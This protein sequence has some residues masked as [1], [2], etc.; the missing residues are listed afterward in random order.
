M[1]CSY[2]VDPSFFS[3]FS[4]R[5]EAET[6]ALAI[7]VL[8]SRESPY[9]RLVVFSTAY[10]DPAPSVAQR[11]ILIDGFLGAAGKPYHIL[12]NIVGQ[13]IP[14]G[15]QDM[16]EVTSGKL[17]ILCLNS[18]HDHSGEWHSTNAY[19]NER[20]TEDKYS[21]DYE[22]SPWSSDDCSKRA[23]IRFSATGTFRLP[24][25]RGAA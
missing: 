13:P 2:I 23:D 18:F 25:S 24:P 3:A 16:V 12:K 1:S 5:G 14:N 19:R 17:S 9:S 20:L 7:E 8:P 21:F 10:D 4:I 6:R 15:H 22:D 11:L